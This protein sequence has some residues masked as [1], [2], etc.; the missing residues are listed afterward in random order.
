MKKSRLTL[1]VA[2]LVVSALAVA[3]C[4]RNK[5]PADTETDKA[6]TTAQITVPATEPQTEA[7]TEPETDRQT[8][9]ADDPQT[10][11]KNE[12]KNEPPVDPQ[13]QTT[14]QTE[15]NPR[16]KLDSFINSASEMYNTSFSKMFGT[17]AD[18]ASNIRAGS[19]TQ[20]YLKQSSP[21]ICV[22]FGSYDVYN[23]PGRAYPITMDCGVDN[24]FEGRSVVTKSHLIEIFGAGNVSDGT[25]EN[26]EK[27]TRTE[28]NGYRLSFRLNAV[29]DGYSEFRI[30]G[31]VR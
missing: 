21:F 4:G 6:D 26:G 28:Y 1:A 27:V 14:P 2:L 7:V 3:S 5:P 18:P 29:G 8:E 17:Q 16:A 24:I 15:P 23:G 19:G 22:Y 10:E 9:R 20:G 11:P 13:P 31:P 25:D 30:F 12:P